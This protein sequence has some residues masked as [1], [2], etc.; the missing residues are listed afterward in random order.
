NYARTHTANCESRHKPNEIHVTTNPVEYTT[1]LT[2]TAATL[3][4]IAKPPGGRTVNG[5]TRTSMRS[6]VNLGSNGITNRM[7][8]KHCLRPVIDVQLAFDPMTV[9]ISRELPEGS[10]R[11]TSRMQHEL[12]H[13]RVYREFLEAAAADIETQLRE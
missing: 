4:D 13:V 7:S 11:F 1:D 12:E 2:V 6:A 8:G 5:L 10:C 9:F 3:T